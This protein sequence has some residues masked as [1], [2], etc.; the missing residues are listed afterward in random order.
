MNQSAPSRPTAIAD[1]ATPA[2][3]YSVMT[4]P[5]VI[6]AIWPT[7]DSV[8]QSPPPGPGVMPDGSLAAVGTG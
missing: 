7:A 4:P 1:G 2:P 8:N 6:C 5:V 3:G